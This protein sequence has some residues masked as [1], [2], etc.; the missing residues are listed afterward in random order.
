M[1]GRRKVLQKNQNRLDQWAEVNC[2]SFDKTKYSLVTTSPCIATGLKQ[3]GWQGAWR[4][5]IWGL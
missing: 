5:M 2:I 3:S 1:P 4:K